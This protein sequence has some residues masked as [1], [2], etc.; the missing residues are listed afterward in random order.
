V[1][2]AKRCIM[3][4]INALY[5]VLLMTQTSFLQTKTPKLFKKNVDKDLKELVEWLR[6]N[7]LSLN[8]DK[9]EFIV[10]R[11]PHKKS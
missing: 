10:F 4:L 6:A 11:P 5:I 7:R 9:T 1:S 8:V 2:S 3:L